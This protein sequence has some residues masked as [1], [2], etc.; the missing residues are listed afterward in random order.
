MNLSLQWRHQFYLFS[1]FS[2][3]LTITTIFI[4]LIIAEDYARFSFLLSLLLYGL[5]MQM[6]SVIFLYGLYRKRKWSYPAGFCLIIAGLLLS[7]G[8]HAF[9]KT[10]ILPSILF[11]SYAVLNIIAVINVLIVSAV[12]IGLSV[13]FCQH[14]ALRKY[15]RS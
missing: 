4:A 8:W 11:L 10:H 14:I 12:L 15:L 6:A 7:L 3:F 5:G 9:F 2:V 1:T 13:A